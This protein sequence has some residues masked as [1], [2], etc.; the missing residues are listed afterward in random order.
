MF[1]ILSFCLSTFL[2]SSSTNV[3]GVLGSVNQ[4]SAPGRESTVPPALLLLDGA[5][6]SRPSKRTTGKLRRC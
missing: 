6:V 5:A 3:L 4:S 1:F 2:L